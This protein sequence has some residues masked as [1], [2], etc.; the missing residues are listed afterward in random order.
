MLRQ[1]QFSEEDFVG[2]LA[3]WSMCCFGE[4]IFVL[5]VNLGRTIILRV[6]YSVRHIYML[7]C[8]FDLKV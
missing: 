3:N 4:I 1:V 8:I 2:N 7:A 6:C 5:I